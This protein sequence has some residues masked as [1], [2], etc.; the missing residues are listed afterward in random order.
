M[1]HAPPCTTKT[2][3][4]RTHSPLVT[5]QSNRCFANKSCLV[6][7]K[8][9]RAGSCYQPLL[10]PLRGVVSTHSVHPPAGG[11]GRRAD[12]H[13]LRWG[14]VLAPSGAQQKLPPVHGSAA[15]IPTN[16]V[17]VHLL[18]ICS[19]EC[20]PRKDTIAESGSEPL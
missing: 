11:S 12:I 18:Q 19:L 14:P 3:S 5:A 20:V 15:Y 6:S 16:Q 9:G 17:S 7:T 13:V 8:T 1:A 10:R 2:G 4:T